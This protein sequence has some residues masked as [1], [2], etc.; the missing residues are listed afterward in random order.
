MR[1]VSLIVAGMLAIGT[2]TAQAQTQAP[3]STDIGLSAAFTAGVA[4]GSAAGGMFGADFAWRLNL[5]WDV[6]VEGGR[7]LNTSTADMQAAANV[8][9]QYLG[10]VSGQTASSNVKQ[11]VNYFAAGLRYKFPTTGRVQP[12]VALGAGA[13]KVERTTSFL[14]NGSDVTAQ[15][16]APPYGVLLGGDLSGSETAALVTLGVGAQIGI[17]HQLFGRELFVDG[18]YRFGRIFLTAGGLNTNRVQ[19]GIGARF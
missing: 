13:G 19:F 6:F 9:A 10:S 17:G 14:V 8:V 7:M 4:A 3:G 2:A 18:S 5:S 15:L 12:Y 11:P 1:R 16:Q